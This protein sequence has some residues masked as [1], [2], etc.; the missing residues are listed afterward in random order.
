MYTFTRPDQTSLVVAFVGKAGILAPNQ[1]LLTQTRTLLAEQSPVLREPAVAPGQIA[2]NLVFSR[3]LP[4]VTPF[5]EIFKQLLLSSVTPSPVTPQPA[6]PQSSNNAAS[7]VATATPEQVPA[8]QG[9]PQPGQGNLTPEQATAIRNTL[10]LEIDTLIALLKQIERVQFGVQ[11]QPEQGVRITKTVFPMANS[12]LAKFSAAQTP[13]KSELLGVIPADSALIGSGLFNFTPEL[14]AEYADLTKKIGN[15]TPGANPGEIA[16]MAQWTASIA[17]SF[18]GEMAFGGFNSTGNALMTQ[19]FSAKDAVA[20]RQLVARYPEM[21]QTITNVYQNAGVEVKM[22]LAGTEPYKGGEIF[23]F[24]FGVKADTLTDPQEKEVFHKIFGSELT[25]P[26][27][28]TGKYG[29]FGLGREARTIVQQMM[30]TLSSQVPP[31]AKFTPAQFGLPE[32]NNLFVYLSLPKLMAWAAQ[33]TPN[34]PKL[35]VRESPG[36]GMTAV[37]KPDQMAGEMFVPLAEVLAVK[38]MLAEAQ[39]A[40]PGAAQPGTST[41]GTTATPQK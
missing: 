33:Y 32:A 17:Q 37:F 26:F 21:A 4:V 1:N 30:D 15:L 2:A 3:I 10:A 22:Q 34:A 8:N 29:M 9:I 28:F 20:A 31:V 7:G 38:A 36:I 24:N 41:P 19:V 11:V 27:G 16:K 23:N 12:A 40:L 18:G 14:I 35:V 5:L 39:P 25:M 13:Q 6:T